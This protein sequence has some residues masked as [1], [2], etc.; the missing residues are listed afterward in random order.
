[1]DATLYDT[2]LFIK[3]KFM[4]KTF[5]IAIISCYCL[6]TSAQTTKEPNCKKLIAKGYTQTFCEYDKKYSFKT[7]L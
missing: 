4:V 1:M 5:L 7:I 6:T 2:N 3:I